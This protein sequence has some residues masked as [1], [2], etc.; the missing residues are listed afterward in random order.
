MTH[1]LV[2]V[3]AQRRDHLDAYAIAEE[4]VPLLIGERRWIPELEADALAAAAHL[5]R[6]EVAGGAAALRPRRPARGRASGNIVNCGAAMY[7]APVGIVNAADPAGRVR[8][9]DRDRVP[10]P[11]ELRPRGGRRAGGRGGR[12]DERRCDRALG[13]RRLA[14]RRPRRHARRR[15]R[16]WPRRRPEWATGR[17]PSRC[18]APPSSP[19]TPSVRSTGRRPWTPGGRAAPRRSRSSRW[20]WAWCWSPTVTSRRQCWA[21]STTAATP[22]RSPAWPARSAA[23]SAGA[24]RCA[25]TGTTGSPRPAGRRWSRPAT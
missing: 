20:R 11:V 3:Y 25:T 13:R 15:S 2:D 4:F 23:H 12:G 24:R 8:R 17:P 7:V 6:R 22:T 21:G 5:P 16:R 9:G 18:C 1:A 14:G 19:S 10:A